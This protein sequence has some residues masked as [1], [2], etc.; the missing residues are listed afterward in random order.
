L[1][2]KITQYD[3]NWRPESE[4]YFYGQ[5][6]K[7]EGVSEKIVMYSFEK[8]K[9]LPYTKRIIYKGDKNFEYTINVKKIDKFPLIRAPD[10]LY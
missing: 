10:C 5:A 2:K 6:A 4:H 1:T 9:E 8:N 3:K 7:N